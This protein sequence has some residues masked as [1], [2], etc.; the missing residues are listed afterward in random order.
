MFR[1][2]EDEF[3]QARRITGESIDAVAAPG[4]TY[5]MSGRKGAALEVLAQLTELSKKRYV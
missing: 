2:A 5:A 1:E 3:V 4:H